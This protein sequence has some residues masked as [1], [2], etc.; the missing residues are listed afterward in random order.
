[1]DAQALA[2]LK[3]IKWLLIGIVV[4]L[5][6]IALFV[7]A[8]VINAIRVS[9]LHLKGSFSDHG[10]ALLDQG[11]HNELIEL[12]DAR[13]Q[14]F[15]GDATAYW[16]VAQAYHRTGN[17][18]RALVSFKK[19]HELQPDYNVGPMIEIIEDKISKEGPRPDLAVVAPFSSFAHDLSKPTDN[20]PSEAPKQ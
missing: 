7:S 2:E 16:L 4:A 6:Y 11:K 10:K 18:R 17:L 19:V 13:L 1:M 15:P 8:F 3:T 5:A 20:G 12:C 14:E 9:R